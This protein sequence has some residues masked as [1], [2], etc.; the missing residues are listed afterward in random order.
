MT[1]AIHI[2][3]TDSPRDHTRWRLSVAGTIQRVVSVTDRLPKTLRHCVKPAL[4]IAE[5][6][7]LGLLR[8][9]DVDQ[10]VSESYEQNQEFYDPRKYRLP[11]EERMIPVLKQEKPTGH[12][13]DA[14]CGQGREAHLFARE[15]YTVSAIDR[16]SWMIERAQHF[17]VEADFEA[18]FTVAEFD[19]YCP[20]RQFDVVYTSC[21]MYSTV[22][23][24]DQRKTFLLRC[25]ELC[26]D[27]GVIIVSYIANRES[28]AV[29]AARFV[30]ARMVGIV[31]GG[32][33]KTEYG[34]RIYSGLFWHHLR[35]Q[36]VDEE[37]TLA[38]LETVSTIE[39][40]GTDPTF[41]LL[42]KG[43]P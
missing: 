41:L 35:K 19:T 5:A 4:V 2:S 20:G 21:W 39:G 31:T 6:I 22:Q 17:A 18:T 38:G 1:A 37:T 34:E 3:D 15:G 10:M 28:Y 27:D 8:S 40:H 9:A 32:N 30:I 16:I 12:L 25:A 43:T 42:R 36:T 13:L 29:A 7:V 24:R 33:W 11:H 23:G 26:S 14:F